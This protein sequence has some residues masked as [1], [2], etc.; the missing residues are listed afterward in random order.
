MNEYLPTIGLEIHAELN[1]KSKMFCGCTNAPDKAEP[2][3]LICPVCMAHPGTLPVINREAVRQV[4]RVGTAIGGTIAD[5]TEFDRKNYFYPDIPKNYQISQY[6]YPLV[7]GGSIGSVE[8]TRI[9]LEEDTARSS[10]SAE[11]SI[12]DF[13][14]AGVPLMELVTEPV[15]HDAETAVA[16]ARDLRL[17]LRYLGASEANLEKGEMRIEA[18]ISIARKGEPFGTKVEVK[19]LNSFKAVEQAIEYEI[20]RHTAALQ[21]GEKIVQETRGWDE[22]RQKTFSQR[23]KENSH[24]Y[25][26][27][28]DP[29]LP[30][31]F[32]SE[33]PGCDSTSLRDSL[34]ELPWDIQKRYVAEGIQPTIAAVLVANLALQ[35]LYAGVCAVLLTTSEQVLAANYLTTDI[36]GLLSTSGYEGRSIELLDPAE[37]AEIIRMV[38]E[39]VLSSRGAKDLLAYWV[40]EGGKPRELAATKGLIQIS[41]DDEIIN[42]IKDILSKHESVVMEY[43]NGKTT[44]LQYLVGQ[45]MKASRGA[46]NPTM[47]TEL[48]QK[49]LDAL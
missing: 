35:R 31:L 25:R 32:V 41:G 30:K 47:L 17:L 19:N 2:N 1:T 48:L 22:N 42:I 36:I 39:G 33:I 46:A 18:N 45:G 38:Q 11:A 14:R 6:K 43:K 37:F 49:E 21:A 20:K 27:F 12:V 3:T 40:V 13:N 7:S 8:V 10:H 26:Y 4:V 16:F 28:P 9:H 34:P 44:A 15:I 29:D 24:D 5:F 23:L